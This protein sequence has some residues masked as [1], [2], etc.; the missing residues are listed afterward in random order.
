LF[1]WLLNLEAETY[2]E[3][4]REMP[5]IIVEAGPVNKENKNRLI[6]RLTE[7][8]SE[9]TGIPVTSYTVLIKEFPVDNWGLG[10]EP[11]D[12]LLSRMQHT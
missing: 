3:E 6:R 10:G 7:T 8:A 12:E 11:L 9:I 1:P 4:G 2:K 5:N